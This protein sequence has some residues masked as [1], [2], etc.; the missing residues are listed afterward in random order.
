MCI[1][2]ADDTVDES[3]IRINKIVRK[4]L[5]VRLADVVSI[6]QVRGLLGLTRGGSRPCS[7][8]WLSSPCMST[9][10]SAMVEKAAVWSGK[11]I[12]EV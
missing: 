9:G 12:R 11:V 10:T 1:V 7:A 2:L 6:H 3:K 4:N 5:R 8:S